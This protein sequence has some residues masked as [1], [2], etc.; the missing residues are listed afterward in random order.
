MGISSWNA[1]SRKTWTCL[2]HVINTVAIDGLVTVGAMTSADKV[3][4]KLSQNILHS[5]P[6]RSTTEMPLCHQSGTTPNLVAK[7]LAT[8]FGCLFLNTCNI[9]KNMFNVGLIIMWQSIVVGGFPITEIW[10]LKNLEGYQLW[11]LFQ[12]INLQCRNKF[13][14]LSM[15]ANEF[16]EVPHTIGC[17]ISQGIVC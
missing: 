6:Q 17:K 16:T 9:F 5:T 14:V 7:I 3:L 4:I 12:K 11:W 2:S 8:N 13:I 15:C 1:S 10:A